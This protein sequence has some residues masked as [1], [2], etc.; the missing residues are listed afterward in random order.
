MLPVGWRFGAVA[1]GSVMRAQITVDRPSP[2]MVTIAVDSKG[3]QGTVPDEIFGSFLEPIDDSINHGVNAE[4]LVNGSL[5][6]GLWNHA[7][8]EAMFRDEPELG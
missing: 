4:I 5:E 3:N 6:A 7:S 1:A 8:L 2:R